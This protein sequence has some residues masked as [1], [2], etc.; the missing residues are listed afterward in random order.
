VAEKN[1]ER[2]NP[3]NAVM[4]AGGKREALGRNRKHF[5]L[6]SDSLVVQLSSCNPKMFFI[7]SVSVPKCGSPSKEDCAPLYPVHF[8]YIFMSS[9]LDYC[10][11]SVIWS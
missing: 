9:L 10:N 5:S 1:D 6:S 7:L 11:S 4:M 2:F 8:T 3:S